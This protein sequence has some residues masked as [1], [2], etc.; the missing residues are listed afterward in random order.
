MEDIWIRVLGR[1]NAWPVALGDEHPFYSGDSA[2]N[3]SNAA[4]SIFS[5]KDEKADPSAINWE[6][7]IDAGHG[8]VQYLLK[9]SNRLPEAIV[10]THAHPDHTLAVDWVVHSH[11]RKYPNGKKFP[12]YAT[13]RS[14][15]FF[16]Q[17]T[18]LMAKYVEHKEL[19]PGMTVDIEETDKLRVT[20]LPTFHGES[21]FGANMLVFEY[22]KSDHM[23]KVVFSGD[24]MCPLLRERDYHYIQDAKYLFV[25]SNNRFP[26]PSSN[27]W[28]FSS[29]DPKNNKISK[30]LTEWKENTSLSYLISTHTHHKYDR[31]VHRYFDQFLAE[32]L[33]SLNIPLT[34]MEFLSYAP[35]K[36]VFLVHY[37]GDDDEK[38]YGEERLTQNELK[39][40]A[41]K[42]VQ[43]FY[44][45]VSIHL[46]NTGDVYKLVP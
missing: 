7:L 6:I 15:E 43:E 28:S 8:T 23:E 4:F 36:D 37:S 29:N 22:P 30:F 2:D 44:L 25:D 24:V 40:W 39:K 9:Y 33:S 32:N 14:W 11:R 17:T 3:F 1:G 41:N 16:I 21:A 45:K 12:I 18:P 13:R 34:I 42:Q 31:I 5:A 19:K 38:I 27:H 26:Y 35:I 10:L 46:P 20:S